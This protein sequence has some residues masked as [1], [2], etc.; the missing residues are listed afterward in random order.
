MEAASKLQRLLEPVEL[1]CNRLQMIINTQKT[2][3]IANEIPSRGATVKF[4]GTCYYPSTRIRYLGMTLESF[5][6]G[7]YL[8]ANLTELKRDVRRRVSLLRR[9]SRFCTT[10]VMS[11]L[12]KA[13]ILG[14][15]NYV[16]PVVGN[17][18]P[19]V[20][21]H[22][23]VAINE[24]MRLDTGAFPSTPIPLLHIRSGF[25]DSEALF[26][27]AAGSLWKK[28]QFGSSVLGKI[29]NNWDG[30]HDGLTPLG[31]VWAFEEAW[32]NYVTADLQLEE[33][34]ICPDVQATEDQLE[35][36]YNCKFSIAANKAEAMDLHLNRRLITE[37]DDYQVWTDGG[38]I[39]HR[40]SCGAIIADGD[41]TVQ[42]ILGGS[43]FPI[44]SSYQAEHRGIVIGLE[45]LKKCEQL[46]GAKA[47]LFCDNRE[48]LQ[49]LHTAKHA[50]ER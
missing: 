3:L 28:I 43:M 19:K 11:T 25:P 7:G 41:G 45:G 46:K 48:I 13:F 38:H 36:L 16:L 14:K 44:L 47:T 20:R 12:T 5:D 15:I 18:D 17:E 32:N 26:R 2:Y 21:R 34:K 49:H 40:G 37:A 23:E 22:I 35:S 8:R 9:V 39:G 27:Y 42:E 10:N 4:C 1:C 6:D 30:R 33:Y 29:Y 50:R 31:R 24:A